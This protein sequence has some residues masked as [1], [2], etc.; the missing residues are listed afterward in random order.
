MQRFVERRKGALVNVVYIAILWA[1][2][3]RPREV[4]R[5]VDRIHK[6]LNRSREVLIGAEVNVR[7]VHRRRLGGRDGE[8]DGAGVA[9]VAPA[10]DGGVGEF[11]RGAR[12]A[13]GR[14][15]EED[16]KKRVGDVRPC[17]GYRRRAVSLVQTAAIVW[18]VG[19]GHRC[20][21]RRIGQIDAPALDWVKNRQ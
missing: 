1:A 21:A 11:A 15:G 9:R 13:V 7:V 20:E 4:G 17:Y 6:E 18:E 5:R 14:R 2:D 8:R 12:G 10:R 3:D 16:V 19:D